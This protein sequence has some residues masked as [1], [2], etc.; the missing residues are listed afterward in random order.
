MFVLSVAALA[1]AAMLLSPFGRAYADPPTQ[2]E[3]TK[4]A[5]VYADQA[6]VAYQSQDWLKA[7]AMYIESYKLVASAEVLFNIATLYDKKVGNKQLALDYYERHN[8]APDASSELIAKAAARINALRQ[9]EGPKPATTD[10][11]VVPVTVTAPP[12]SDRRQTF[13]TAGLVTGLLGLAGIGVGIGFGVVAI[14][15]AGE[16]HAAGCMNNSCPDAASAEKDRS[17]FTSGTVS[18]VTLVLGGALA[19]V[20]ITLVIIAPKK[21]A[22][23]ATR[24]SLQLTPS[25]GPNSVGLGFSGV[26][27]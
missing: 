19:V 24:A 15:K 5:Q 1:V 16:A 22:K 17:A 7:I 12:P 27:F 23:K 3:R 4:Q 6:Y 9:K 13:R 26:M 14:G 8:G 11:P 10:T 21:A 2:A 18:T 20:G 25:V